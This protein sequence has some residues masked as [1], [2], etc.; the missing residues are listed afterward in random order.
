VSSVPDEESGEV[1]GLQNTLT[2]LGASI[3][4]ALSGAVLVAALTASLITGI[5]NNP[6][7]PARVKSQAQTQLAS[8]VPFISDKDLKAALDEA[9]VPNKTADAIVA[10]NSAARLDALRSSLSVIALIALVAMV[11]SFGIPERQPT[12]KPSESSPEDLGLR[13]P[14]A[15]ATAA[16]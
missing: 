6:D 16:S 1:G 2:N 9:H 13:D 15:D 4:T 5:Q 8:G 14:V 11:C 10:E 12:G 7:V 3:G